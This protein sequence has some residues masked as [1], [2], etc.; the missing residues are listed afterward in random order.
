MRLQKNF[1]ITNTIVIFIGL[2]AVIAILGAY[3]FIYQASD[4][5]FENNI[6]RLN[7][8]EQLDKKWSVAILDTR[9]YTLQDFDQLA[10]YMI[11]IRNVLHSLDQYGM[12][13]EKQVGIRTV[14][15]YK[16]YKYSFDIKNEA[17][18]HYKS[19]QAI[20]RN[21]VLYLPTISKELQQVFIEKE[22]VQREVIS[23]LVIAANSL[24][25]QFLLSATEKDADAARKKL[26]LLY[27][28]TN[29]ES[30]EI[31]S[32]VQLYL[33]HVRLILKYNPQVKRML[34]TAM[35]SNISELS[36]NV[37]QEY[38][39]FQQAIKTRIRYFQQI[40]LWGGI[41]L[42]IIMFWFLRRL[43]NSNI[44]TIVA[45][46]E[47]QAIQQQL[48]QAEAQ[49]G[50]VSR[51]VLQTERYSA[52]GQLAM[53]IFKQL[54]KMTPALIH[55]I[56]FLNDI[57]KDVTF[58]Q[59]KEKL[60]TI[61][62]NINNLMLKIDAMDSLIIPQTHYNTYTDLNK[63]IQRSLD[64]ASFEVGKTIIFSKQ[65]SSVPSIQANPIDIFQMVLKLLRQA[66][67]AAHTEKQRVFVKTW[68]TD[69]H[70]NIYITPTGLNDLDS[71]YSME[72]FTVMQALLLK[73]RAV[74]KLTTQKNQ[75]NGM[76]WLSFTSLTK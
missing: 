9:S 21:A 15:Q 75:K 60:D 41:V 29:N 33:T 53:G 52:S 76:F 37:V 50:K 7:T 74:L 70:T 13:D 1:N 71:L 26:A 18:E 42:L 25:K 27:Q 67:K 14:S 11:K 17:V 39:Q 20:L 31:V 44:K 3:Y 34:K 62:K 63:I 8:L 10:L 57:K 55:D 35:A 28:Q 58:T 22:T 30:N 72:E 64:T 66:V 19:Q 36:T 68:A 43:R 69:L 49:I 40:M 24:I 23:N 38:T 51:Y 56:D 48:L 12:L 32:K 61:E 16:I 73:N 65:L 4:N 47:S 5:T 59:Y 45:D 46:Q 54:Q 6:K 2:L